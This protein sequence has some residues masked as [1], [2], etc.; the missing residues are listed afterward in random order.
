MPSPNLID[1]DAM[2]RLASRE[3]FTVV[4]E[5]DVHSFLHR[6]GT[7]FSPIAWSAVGFAGYFARVLGMSRAR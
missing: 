2:A 6:G 1:V 7:L 4:R 5:K 3:T